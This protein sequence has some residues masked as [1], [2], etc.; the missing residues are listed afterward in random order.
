MG[1]YNDNRNTVRESWRFSHTG[2]E[3]LKAATRKLAQYETEETNARNKMAKLMVDKSVAMSSREVTDLQEEIE[4]LSD[5]KEKCQIWV[6]EF[7]RNQG[8]A[9]SLGMG[10]ISFFDLHVSN[11]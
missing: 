4:H 1:M 11:D 8:E 7:N 2:V 5:L 3:L 9:Y 6:Y 10:D